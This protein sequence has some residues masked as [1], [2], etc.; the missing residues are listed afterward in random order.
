MKHQEILKKL[1]PEFRADSTIT[2]VML[3][4]SVASG[5][6]Y[7][8]SDLDL[9]ILGKKNKFES[10]I[11]DEIMVEYLYINHETAQSRLDKT[12]MEIYHYLGSKIIYDLDGRLIKLMRS[13]MNKLKN[14]KVN[15]RDKAE[16]RHSLY[17]TKVKIEA[18][19]SCNTLLRADYITATASW[20]AVEA[21]FAVN[22]I[23]LPPTY[24]VMQE[25]PNITLTPMEGWFEKLFGKDTDD[26]TKILLHIINWILMYL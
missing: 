12:G 20:K 26:R 15:D 7:P 1:I 2:G 10:G 18:A 9:F 14:Y 22:E 5:S 23:P 4:G 16:I 3:M 13:A 11:I 21:I 25:L 19:V 17:S 6:E 24:R 8:T